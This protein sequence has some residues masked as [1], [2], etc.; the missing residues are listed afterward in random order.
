MV[1]HGEAPKF[2]LIRT[3]PRWA[4]GQRHYVRKHLRTLTPELWFQ[5]APVQLDFGF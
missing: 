4:H 3:Y 2:V 1:E 5:S